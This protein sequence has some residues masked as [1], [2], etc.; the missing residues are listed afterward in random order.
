[1]QR[2]SAINPIWPG[3]G[4]GNFTPPPS[5]FAIIKEFK[6]GSSIFWFFL[7]NTCPSIKAERW[8]YIPTT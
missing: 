7:T 2:S 4:G 5:F 3:G 8:A 1:M 6:Q